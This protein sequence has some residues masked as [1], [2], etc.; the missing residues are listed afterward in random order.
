[1]NLMDHSEALR[2]N[3]VGFLSRLPGHRRAPDPRMVCICLCSCSLSASHGNSRPYTV[4]LMLL[5]AGE[6]CEEGELAWDFCWD[7]GDFP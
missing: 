3:I 6:L 7:S 5:L 4:L 2:G 1:M